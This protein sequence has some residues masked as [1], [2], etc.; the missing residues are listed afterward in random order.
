MT[1]RLWTDLLHT[2]DVFTPLHTDHA[3]HRTDVSNGLPD[4]WCE[5]DHY[6]TDFAYTDYSVT[7]QRELQAYTGSSIQFGGNVWTADVDG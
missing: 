1:V 4:M 5:P 6:S 2:R 3:V 7:Q